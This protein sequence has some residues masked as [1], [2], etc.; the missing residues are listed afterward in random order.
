MLER[1]WGQPGSEYDDWVWSQDFNHSEGVASDVV[2][3]NRA[4]E[5]IRCDCW[6]CRGKPHMR[7]AVTHGEMPVQSHRA[8]GELES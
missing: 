2:A 1:C 8:V 4:S 5:R 6:R 7:L 3:S